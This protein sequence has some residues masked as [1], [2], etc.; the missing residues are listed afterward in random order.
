MADTEVDTVKQGPVRLAD[1][2][3]VAEVPSAAWGW[4]GEAPRAYRIAGWVVVVFLLCMLRGNHV[5]RVE[6]LFLV[7]FAALL[8][9]VLLRDLVRSRK[10]R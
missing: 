3:T 9:V 7:G 2:D 1:A 8:A 10:P 6:D 5:G 4:S